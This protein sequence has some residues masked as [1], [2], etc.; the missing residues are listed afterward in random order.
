MAC[1]NR[2]GVVGGLVTDPVYYLNWAL[3]GG[4]EPECRAACDANG[5][6]FIG[7][8]VTDAVYYLNWAFTGGAVPRNGH[9]FMWCCTKFLGNPWAMRPVD[10]VAVCCNEWMRVHLSYFD[11][12]IYDYAAMV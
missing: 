7:G 11:F 4:P 10:S 1:G 12:Y 3:S 8:S 5:D 6:G 9:L 2:V